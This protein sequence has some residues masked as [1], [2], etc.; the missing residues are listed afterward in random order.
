MTVVDA[1]VLVDLQVRF[2][3]GDAAVPDAAALLTTV[4]GLLD[5]A[6]TAG[7]LVVHLQNDGAPGCVDEPGRPGWALHFPPAA[8][9]PVV[10]KRH[11]DG[12]RDTELERLLRSRHTVRPALAGL[13]SEMCV[14][15]TARAAMDRG[16]D[17]VLAHDCH[18]TYD[19]PA[20]AGFGPAVP[21]A[22]VAR[23]AEWALGDA[24]RLVPSA[25][26]VEF[27]RVRASAGS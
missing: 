10:R 25:V 13:M 24:V 5:R 17:V 3:A 16:F 8:D 18:A 12:F 6:R 27:G 7:S 11:D 9:E 4:A 22:V 26:G 19:I 20:A 1:L 15:A 23:V 2:V 21:A 14:S